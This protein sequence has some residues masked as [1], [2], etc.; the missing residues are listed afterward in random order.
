VGARQNGQNK[1]IR[2]DIDNG[3]SQDDETKPLRWRKA[4]KREN[5]KAGANNDV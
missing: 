2:Q 1:K 4:G 5:R 3:A